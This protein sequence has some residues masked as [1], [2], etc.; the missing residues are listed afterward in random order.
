MTFETSS[1]PIRTIPLGL[2]LLNL[3]QKDPLGAASRFQNCFGDVARLNI[4]FRR[5]YYFFSPESARQILVDHQADFTREARLL[6]I[7]ASFRARMY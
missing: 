5:I 3:I 6:K 7:F 1:A 2:P 4:L